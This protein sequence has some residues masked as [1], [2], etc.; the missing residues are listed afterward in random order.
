MLEKYLVVAIV[1]VACIILIIYT[2]IDSSKKEDKTL[3]FKE[4][5]QKEFPN[6]KVIERNQNLII[7]RDAPDQRIPDELVLIRI[8][9]EQ[10]KNIRTSGKL[11]ILTYTKQPNIREV[12]KD[13]N[14]NLQ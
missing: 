7:C 4:K 1:F 10:K 6:F 13:A 8:D 5:L 12:R 3:S 14:P 11:L 9:P 2:Q